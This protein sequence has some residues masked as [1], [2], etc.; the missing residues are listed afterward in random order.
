[1]DVYKWLGQFQS[2]ISGETNAQCS[3]RKSA[4]HKRVMSSLKG[5]FAQEKKQKR[6]RRR[7][8]Y[9]K[10]GNEKQRRGGECDILVSVTHEAGG[11]DEHHCINSC[12]S[13]KLVSVMIVSFSRHFVAK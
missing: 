9:K 6:R 1:M 2:M 3:D 12:R 5:V 8:R 11:G 10:R 7:K 4:H 13:S